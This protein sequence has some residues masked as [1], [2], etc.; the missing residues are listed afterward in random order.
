MTPTPE[1]YDKEKLEALSKGTDLYI[2][3]LKAKAVIAYKQSLLAWLENFQW[4]IMKYHKKYDDKN[5]SRALSI[6]LDK[7]AMLTSVINH[8]KQGGE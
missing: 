3:D 2:K 7:Q 6:A 8:I 4:N 1:Q 5:D